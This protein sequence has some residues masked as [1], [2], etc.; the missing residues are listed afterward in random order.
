MGSNKDIILVT[1]DQGLA[2]SPMVSN[3]LVMGGAGQGQP[4]VNGQ[5]A[6]Q[7]ELWIREFF[8]RGEE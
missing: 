2:K 7:T 4:V 3:G 8:L 6:A 1:I 5:W